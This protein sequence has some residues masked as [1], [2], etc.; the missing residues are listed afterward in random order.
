MP[1]GFVSSTKGSLLKNAGILYVVVEKS[2]LIILFT[3]G[4]SDIMRLI[5]LD[6]DEF[7]MAVVMYCW[8]FF[9]KMLS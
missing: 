2:V 1:F 8:K 9:K 7:I 4:R 3:M 5:D 6:L